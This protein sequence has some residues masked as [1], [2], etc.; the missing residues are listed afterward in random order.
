VTE[1]QIPR[2]RDASPAADPVPPAVPGDAAPIEIAVRSEIGRL[3]KVMIH[4][5]GPEMDRM[6]PSMM[7]Q[8]LFDDILF[9]EGARV[10]H[11]LFR[12]LLGQVA[13]EVLDVEDVLAE[14]LQNPDVRS[15]LIETMAF[16]ERLPDDAV[17]HLVSLDG[18]ELARV[19]IRGI[20]H[21]QRDYERHTGPWQ[22]Y[23][24]PPLANLFFIR[25]P[26]V[27]V[28]DGALLCSMAHAARKREPLLLKFCYAFHPRLRLDRQKLFYFDDIAM[29]ALRRRIHIPGLEGGDT[30]VI[31]DRV[32]VI[33]A[34]ERTSEVAVDLLAETLR[35][36]TS[37][38]TVL[39]VLMP[40][41]RAMMHLDTVFTMI[42]RNEALIYPPMFE[43]D[44]YLLLPVVKKDVRGPHVQTEFKASLLGALEDEG[45][46]LEPIRCGGSDAIA[47]QREQW[48][49][50]ANAFAL[51]PGIITLYE[52][53]SYTIRELE[54][55]GY[56][57]V[58][59]ADVVSGQSPL[60][61]DESRKYV[62]LLDGKELS[63]ARGGPRCM[64]MPLVRDPL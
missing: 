46:V 51:A 30:L 1:I 57:T 34:S 59:S 39:L 31:S 61:L 14:A 16:T 38:E 43:P 41:A 17:E 19:A 27:T 54:R 3:R 21:P 23:L 55:H 25:D 56:H 58:H 45:I 22:P 32:L 13:D 11:D 49:D 4:R 50:G 6:I 35:R 28:G 40:K 26:L 42:S 47:Q 44:G 20:E 64:T 24:M 12:R 63:R 18:A 33:G 9:G 53:N 36:G 48:T 37:I 10:E 29:E 7:D 62:I 8:L 60:V 15:S 5:P 52:R 2:A